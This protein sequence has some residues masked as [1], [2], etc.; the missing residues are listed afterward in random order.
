EILGTYDPR[1]RKAV[2]TKEA[3]EKWINSGA[4]LSDTVKKI[5]AKEGVSPV[6]AAAK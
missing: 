5:F 6:A 2:M 3:A 4:Q 1:N